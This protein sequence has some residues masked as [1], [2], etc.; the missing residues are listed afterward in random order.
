MS[1]RRQAQQ[2]KTLLWDGIKTVAIDDLPDSAWAWFSRNGGADSL[3]GYY[4]AVPWLFRAVTMRADA[5]AALPFAL[6]K[7]GEDYDA[8]DD[9]Q[10]KV[11]FLPDPYG[12][13]WLV[14]AALCLCNRAY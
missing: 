6:V 4:K 13:L 12:L 7:G 9:W 8:S 3:Q 2:L 1:K 14:E 11:K 10:N 5:V